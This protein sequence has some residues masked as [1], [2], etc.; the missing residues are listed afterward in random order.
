MSI[1]KL[2]LIPSSENESA[3]MISEG[4]TP[5]VIGRAPTEKK[6]GRDINPLRVV[7]LEGSSV[8][9]PGTDMAL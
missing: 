9:S 2:F 5:E 4:A 1:T 3:S 7:W 8:N 6:G